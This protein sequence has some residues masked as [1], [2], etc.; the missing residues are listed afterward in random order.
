MYLHLG[1][2]CIVRTSEIIGIFDMDTL[3]ASNET[4]EF[5]RHM[6]KN[7]KVINITDDIPKSFILCQSKKDTK[8]YL[9]LLNTSTLG[10]RLKKYGN[11]AD[12]LF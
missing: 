5:L 4:N 11:Y 7:K 1:N 12:F 9:S 3:S 6:D 8:V 10:K 2:D